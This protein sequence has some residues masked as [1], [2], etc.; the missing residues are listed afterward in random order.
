MTDDYIHD[1]E[2]VDK[3]IEAYREAGDAGKEG[4]QEKLEQ[5]LIDE[6]LGLANKMLSDG[7]FVDEL[8]DDE[9]IERWVA[10]CDEDE[11]GGYQKVNPKIRSEADSRG[12]LEKAIKAGARKSESDT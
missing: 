1:P 7:T 9:L 12:L 10:S 8:S 2:R 5:I 3:I 11:S 6:T 4:T